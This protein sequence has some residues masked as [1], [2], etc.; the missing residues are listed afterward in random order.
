[1]ERN[2]RDDREPMSR[3]LDD[4]SDNE[5]EREGIEDLGAGLTGGKNASPGMGAGGGLGSDIRK[6][7]GSGGTA[8]SNMGVGVGMASGTAGGPSAA[9]RRNDPDLEDETLDNG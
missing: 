5:S 4:T 9:E 8:N 2:S 1:M 7:E 3:E 6:G